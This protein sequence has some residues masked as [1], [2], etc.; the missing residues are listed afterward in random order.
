MLRAESICLSLL[1]ILTVA[2]CDT[3]PSKVE[4]RDVQREEPR[5]SEHAYL[6]DNAQRAR[7]FAESAERKVIDKSSNLN[8]RKAD[9]RIT[10]VGWFKD[11]VLD[12]II[13][14]R[15]GV[16]H[17]YYGEAVENG[18]YSFGCAYSFGQDKAKGYV[19]R[20]CG[21]SKDGVLEGWGTF[22]EKTR[23]VFLEYHN[24]KM[25]GPGL[26]CECQKQ[27]CTEITNCKEQWYLENALTDARVRK[28]TLPPESSFWPPIKSQMGSTSPQTRDNVRA[29]GVGDV[30]AAIRA[31][32]N[33][34]NYK[35]VFTSASIKLIEDRTCTL[36]ELREYGGWVKSQNHKSQPI[37]FTY[38]GGT[39]IRNRIYI[40]ASTGNVFR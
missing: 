32:D 28:Y 9:D 12:K 37:Y 39:S 13:V 17:E 40:D 23:I 2:G 1:A 7:S 4:E 8:W 38:C 34:G 5:I 15:K 21:Q 30:E 11:D 6:R 27:G 22:E 35:Q 26:T 25:N 10:D 16:A 36:A 20:S 31:S 14:I 33:F 29:V 18:T 3:N 24:G 19:S